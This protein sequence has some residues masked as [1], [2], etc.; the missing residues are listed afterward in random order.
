MWAKECSYTDRKLLALGKSLYY[1]VE[2]I[3]VVETGLTE[4]NMSFFLYKKEIPPR[5]T[6]N[7]EALRRKEL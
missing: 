5:L 7:A 2:M 6:K 4:M 1:S 3:G